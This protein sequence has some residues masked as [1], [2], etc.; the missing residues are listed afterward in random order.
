MRALDESTADALRRIAILAKEKRYVIMRR[1]GKQIHVLDI[2]VNTMGEE[3]AN[4]I[5]QQLEETGRSES[6]PFGEHTALFVA[7]HAAKA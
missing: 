4:A 5:I 2:Q 1:D 3:E 7:P 6:G